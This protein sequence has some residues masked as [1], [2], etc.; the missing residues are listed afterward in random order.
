MSVAFH[1][2]EDQCCPMLEFSC[3]MSVKW[4]KNSIPN[5]IIW[6]DNFISSILFGGTTTG[7]II[8]YKIHSK[9]LELLDVYPICMICSHSSSITSIIECNSFIYSNCIASLSNDGTVSIIS[10]EDLTVVLNQ[11]KLF[12]EGSQYFASHE[13]NQDLLLASQAYGTIEVAN[14]FDGSIIYRIYGF[15]S[16]IT[17]ISCHGSMHSINCAD[18]SCYILGISD[19]TI[20][21]T[22]SVHSQAESRIVLSPDFLHAVILTPKYWKLIGEGYEPYNKEIKRAH[23]S[24]V[25]VEWIDNIHFFVT[26]VSGKIEVWET[27]SKP[28]HDVSDVFNCNNH[29]LHIDS[30]NGK[31]VISPIITH[32]NGNK[33]DLKKSPPNRISSNENSAGGINNIFIVTKDG[34]IVMSPG[35]SIIELRSE[36]CRYLCNLSSCFT[37]KY[38]CRCA[39]GDPIIHEARVNSQN[40][41]FLDN[42]SSPIGEH[43]DAFMLFSPPINGRYFLSFSRD[44]SIKIWTNKCI[45]TLNDLTEPVKSYYYIPE[46]KFIVCIGQGVSFLVIDTNEWCSIAL[47]SGHDSEIVEVVFK[48]GMFHSRTVS[49]SI[50]TWSIEGVML[51]KR[52]CK[53]F[54]NIGSLKDINTSVT[55]SKSTPAM[56]HKVSAIEKKQFSKVLQLNIPN[57]QTFAVTLDVFGFVSSF[58]AFD[59]LPIRTD[60]QFFPLLLLW[61]SHN[62]SN[63]CSGYPVLSG[64]QYAFAGDNYTVT[65]P[66]SLKSAHKARID[67]Q[68]KYQSQISIPRSNKNTGKSTISKFIIDSSHVEK[69]IVTSSN[70]FN[71][72]PLLSAV[73]SCAASTLGQC[74]VSAK[75]DDELSILSA[76]SQT[77]TAQNLRNAVM[78]SF[79]VLANWLFQES[80]D[81]RVIIHNVISEVFSNMSSE[82]ALHVVESIEHKF[83]QW[84]VILPFV[85]LYAKMFVLP[86]HWAKEA[87]NRLF[88]TAI[89]HPE[90]LDVLVSC[91][92]TILPFINNITDFYRTLFDAYTNGKIEDGK[93]IT[94]ALKKPLEF[95]EIVKNHP[96]CEALIS[97]LIERW[98][99]PDLNLVQ[100]MLIRFAANESKTSSVDYNRI[101]KVAEKRFPFFSVSSQ[102]FVFGNDYGSII[103]IERYTSKK[104][105]DVQLF[106]SKI[107][108]VSIAPT[109]GRFVVLSIEIG[110]MTWISK[111]DPKSKDLFE[112]ASTIPV[113][114]KIVP[115]RTNWSGDTKLQLFSSTEKIFEGHAPNLSFF[116]R[117]F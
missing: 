8:A 13:Y 84:T 45:E 102:Y 58:D 35:K 31:Q 73:H 100:T 76:V 54:K 3:F 11:S 85:L 99:K 14:V 56:I 36:K 53:M 81:L 82:S 6:S 112:L 46:R 24:F 39:I 28:S 4:G 74:F 68:K 15:S 106:D 12:S 83:S 9:N 23:D 108:Y 38:R 34:F 77:T 32:E 107:S 51:S 104:L 47:C 60:P 10:V 19:G 89:L 90:I 37:S 105:W 2:W 66:I 61:S 17:G 88:P 64:F 95:Y 29:V 111:G 67:S 41:V 116:K 55:K 101:F 79:F 110:L 1:C 103:V 75:D 52:K 63:M 72:S 21:Y 7:T 114:V 25:S 43:K 22:F 40:E 62:G 49:S 27:T 50:Y 44:G 87:T 115:Y 117:L 97:L 71:L 78:P 65:L 42:W 33:G 113:G 98:I 20:N 5:S 18:G 69:A 86:D 16:L 91:F 92:N 30:M 96:K 57:C 70:A 59:R 80:S 109:G 26:T 93:I 94:F 48:N